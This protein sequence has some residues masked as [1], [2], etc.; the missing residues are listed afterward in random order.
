MKSKKNWRST[1]WSSASSRSMSKSMLMPFN[2]ASMSVKTTFAST[3]PN[4]SSTKS[5]SRSLLEVMS[6]NTSTTR[7]Q[8]EPTWPLSSTVSLNVFYL[9][10]EFRRQLWK[11]KKLSK[12]WTQVT[13][14]Q[15]S[16]RKQSST[17]LQNSIKLYTWTTKNCHRVRCE[18]FYSPQISLIQP[19]S[20]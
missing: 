12:S 3:Q 17:T 4:W 8:K 1:T 9:N 5:K 13:P 11:L 18:T 10:K 7:S 15:R 16:L 6:P 14:F 2:N 19:E 20:I